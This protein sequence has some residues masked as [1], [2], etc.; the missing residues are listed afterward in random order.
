MFRFL[1]CIFCISLINPF[2]AQTLDALTYKSA[3]ESAYATNSTLPKGILEAVAFAQT[4]IK[5][6]S[7]N[8]EG[9]SGMPQVK[10]VMGL[11]EDGKGYFNN[12]LIYIAELSGYSVH[13]IRSNP[14]DNI[15]A[16]AKAYTILMERSSVET[17]EFSKHDQLLKT[18]SEI[19]WNK[20]AASNYAL[21]C[22][23]YE[24]FNFL[25]NPIYQD[26]FD[27]PAYA[28]D[29]TE[30][31]GVDN[32]GILTSEQILISPDAVY[33]EERHE[34]EPRDR[35]AEYGP[36]LWNAA[37]ACN[38]SSR[39]G[40]SISAVTVH[41]IQGSYAGA[42]SWAKNCLSSVSYHYVVRSSD[43]Q[44]T[45]MVIEANKAWHVG[46]ANPYTI[47]IE[48]EGYVSDP[49]WYTEAMYVSSANL[50]RDITESGY[51]I[52]PLRTYQ[53]PA[54][55]ATLTLGGCVKIKGH[56]HFPGAAHTDPGIH[57]NW[58]HYYQ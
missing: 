5:H 43:G 26:L 22:F 41:T 49:I 45:Q 52:D 58:E 46:S 19:P 44:V 6:L 32:L 35:S 2:T 15:A 34:F 18:L 25:N 8:T 21:S 13:D 30:I 24:V 31:Y 16:Y 11:T 39:L 12:N 28:I 54:T 29:L 23:T 50:V 55:A 17:D 47:G 33:D 9:C 36:A 48:H 10:G 56:Q 57:W 14:S 7:G 3:F 40:V 42:I 4:R 51:G 1:L 27:F 20:N 53:G 37:A 38:Y